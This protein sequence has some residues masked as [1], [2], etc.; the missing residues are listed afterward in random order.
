MPPVVKRS[1]KTTSDVVASSVSHRRHCLGRGQ[2]SASRTANEE[3][4]VV[5]LHAECLQFALQ[6]LR[7]ARIDRLVGEGL[8]LDENGPLADR[9]EIWNPDIGPLGARAHIDELR[10]RT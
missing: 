2:A 4:F 1:F 6:T 7:K 3:E 5:L 9:R 10:A 8:P